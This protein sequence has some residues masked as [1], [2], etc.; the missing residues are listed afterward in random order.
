MVKLPGDPGAPR[1][2]RVVYLGVVL[3][4]LVVL[5]WVAWRVMM[6]FVFAGALAYLLAPLV[7]WLEHRRI[8]RA[9]GVL[10]SYAL[11][12]IAVAALI[13]YL[14]PMA[15]QQS[16]TLVR[17]LPRFIGGAQTTWDLALTRFHQA[18]IPGAV[19]QAINQATRHLQGTAVGSVRTMVTILFALVPGL[20]A[21]V[22]SPVLAF[23][24]LKDLNHIKARF[25]QVIPVEW[26]PAVFKL[27]V[28]LDR[29]LSGY[30]RGQL[31]VALLVGVLSA[32]WTAFLG[33]PFAILIGILAG[34]TDVI[35]YIGP[36]VGALPAVLLGFV[37]SPW[38][39]LYALIGF[40][41]IHQLEGTV[42]APQVVG[43]AVGLH[44][45]MIVLAI[46]VGG[47]LAGLGGMLV[48][49]PAAAAVKVMASHLYRRLAQNGGMEVADS[50]YRGPPTS[51]G[52]GQGVSPDGSGTHR[53]AGGA[54]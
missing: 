37:K 43:D 19:R 27:G 23:Y 4:T 26:Q 18:P 52:R 16:L 29:T 24:L 22:V 7:N 14:L 45:L 46:L 38:I 28:D 53:D 40:I 44:P 21:L 42:I 48:A 31:A 49:V 39:G 41:A 17:A 6:P 10:I 5:L 15:V 25:W 35:P 51:A 33:I 11:V 20:I 30:I 2:V 8:H 1:A 12:A 36:I 54:D 9:L 50:P 47:D 34:V 13:L 32:S 3:C